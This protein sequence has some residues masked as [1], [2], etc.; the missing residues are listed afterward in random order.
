MMAPKLV[1]VGSYAT[2]ADAHIAQHVLK[3]SGIESVLQNEFLHDE[4]APPLE[5]KVAAAD[6]VRARAMLEPLIQGFRSEVD[7]ARRLACPECGGRFTAVTW[8][9]PTRTLQRLATLF[10]RH[11]LSRAEIKCTTCGHA[12][13]VR[14]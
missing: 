14:W 2:L 10:T 7:N 5:L 11:D 1:A 3:Q 9:P 8:K 6:V 12:W 4:A 13:T